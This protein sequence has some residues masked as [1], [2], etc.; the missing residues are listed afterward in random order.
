M[1]PLLVRAFL[2]WS[3]RRREEEEELE[4][5]PVPVN[6]I[7]GLSQS[8]P[9]SQAPALSTRPVPMNNF[10]TPPIQPRLP[11]LNS[12]LTAQI[13]PGQ[14]LTL[15]TLQLQTPL[16]PLLLVLVTLLVTLLLLVLVA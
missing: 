4:K 13:P 12:P 9:Q 8:I 14:T 16:L 11:L 2:L 6:L 7:P 3:R 10:P 15:L 1:L 5:P